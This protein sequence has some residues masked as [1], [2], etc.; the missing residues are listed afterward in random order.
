MAKKFFADSPHITHFPGGV[1]ISVGSF[2][3]FSK[4][5]GGVSDCWGKFNAYIEFNGAHGIVLS[6][7]R[8]DA[9]GIRSSCAKDGVFWRN[10]ALMTPGLAAH[11]VDA[12]KASPAYAAME[13]YLLLHA[14]ASKGLVS[15]FSSMST[16]LSCSVTGLPG[17]LTRD[18]AEV[19]EVL[20]GR[21]RLKA[22][23]KEKRVAI[24]EAKTQKAKPVETEYTPP[25]GLA[26][27]L[28]LN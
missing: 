24:R 2:R 17:I 6:D 23:R 7:L 14:E 1:S 27:R 25:K 11:V 13:P 28:T 12:V 16:F 5:D 21:K 18:A 20:Q 10:F 22:A 8:I 15:S 19:N 26:K 4:T 3:I 9:G